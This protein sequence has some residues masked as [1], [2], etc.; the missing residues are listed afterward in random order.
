M[1]SRDTCNST[2]NEMPVK[3][4][5]LFAALGGS[6]LF[7]PVP[8][9]WLSWLRYWLCADFLLIA[10]GYGPFRELARCGSIPLGGAVCTSAGQLPHRGI[11]HVAGINMLWRSSEST[12]RSCV[13]NALNLAVERGFQS[14]AFP[15]I[16]AGTGGL[17]RDTAL[18][19]MREQSEAAQFGGE[20]RIVVYSRNV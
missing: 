1:K 17:A 7:L 18:R 4:A 20:I 19:A 14:V 8:T 5:L 3:Y 13:D 10:L 12:V 15:V 9:Q 2:T 16:G 11:I 6:L